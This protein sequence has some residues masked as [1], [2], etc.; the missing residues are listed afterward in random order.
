MQLFSVCI[1]NGKNLENTIPLEGASV[2]SYFME[3]NSVIERIN[4][5]RPAEWIDK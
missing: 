1:K 5:I 2:L 4:E 3:F